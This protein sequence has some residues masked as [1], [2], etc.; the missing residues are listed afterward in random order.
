MATA[1]YREFLQLSPGDRWKSVNAEIDR[2][3]SRKP[4]STYFDGWAENLPNGRNRTVCKERG[5]INYMIGGLIYKDESINHGPLLLLQT[6]AE[7]FQIIDTS[8]NDRFIRPNELVDLQRQVEAAQIRGNSND[9]QAEL[10]RLL[11]L[12]REPYINLRMLGYTYADLKIDFSK[13]LDGPA[14]MPLLTPTG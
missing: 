5:I 10:Y 6:P 9:V 11:S 14:Y 8:L 3:W 12:V 13:P 4:N 2:E 1:E 7:F